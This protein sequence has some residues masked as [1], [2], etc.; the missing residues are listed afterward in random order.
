[1]N[2]LN[3]AFI[4][5]AAKLIELRSYFMDVAYNIGITVFTIA[6]LSAALNYALTGEGLKQNIIKLFK[7][8]VFFMCIMGAYP[9]IISNL[10]SVTYNWAYGAAGSKVEGVIAGQN[11]RLLGDLAT[12][13]ERIANA[14]STPVTFMAVVSLNQEQ[15]AAKAKELA[16]SSTAAAAQRSVST[17]IASGT[18]ATIAGTYTVLLPSAALNS[19]LVVSGECIRSGTEAAR[20]NNE[21]SFFPDLGILFS[22][23]VCAFFVMLTG[24]F[25][26]LEYVMAYMEFLFISSVGVIMLPMSMWDGSKFLT[27]KLISAIVGFT[28]KLLF[29]NVCIFLLM[30]GLLS[31]AVGFATRPFEGYPDQIL[32]I[33]FTCL[34][35]FYI[36][37]S[38]PGLA[39]SLL[40]GSPSLNAAGAIGAAGAAFGAAGAAFGAVAAAG[41]LGAQAGKTA[42]GAATSTVAGAVGGAKQGGV[43]GALAGAAGGAGAAALSIAKSAG[44]GLAKSLGISGGASQMADRAKAGYNVGSATGSLAAGKGLPKKPAKQDQGKEG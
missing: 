17:K 19:I 25:A 38:A 1:M 4:F 30:W 41:K 8:T 28:I 36:C 37:K 31:L 16:R 22:S 9:W 2:G 15:A 32:M 27:E 12:I 24:C 29:A 20:K 14:V 44:G 26:I 40:T 6:L 11:A 34:L 23:F 13:N 39:Q 21:G 35:F 33:I 5:V 42:A 10:C 7:A 18:R 3:E 43:A